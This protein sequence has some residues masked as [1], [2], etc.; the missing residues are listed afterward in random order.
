MANFSSGS[1]KAIVQHIQ[2][3]VN[4]TLEVDVAPVV[5][6]HI[7]DS[8]VENVY[9]KGT[10]VE[11]SR[12]GEY[13]SGYEGSGSLRDPEEMESDVVNGVLEVSDEASPKKM[14]GWEYGSLSE[15]ISYGYGDESNW[16]NEAR[17]FIPEASQKLESDKAHV[18]ALKK[19]LQGIYGKNNVI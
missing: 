19:G 1:L 2:E 3:S 10:P 13:E 11:Y 17:S 5:K 9:S 8:V 4:K 12:R 16:W 15:A 7:S 18:K 6:K 14:E